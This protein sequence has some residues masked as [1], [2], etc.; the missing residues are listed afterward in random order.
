MVI[1]YHIYSS[2][3]HRLTSGQHLKLV[4]ICYENLKLILKHN[5]IYDVS[6]I[7]VIA[8]LFILFLG[9]SSIKSTDEKQTNEKITIECLELILKQVSKIWKNDQIPS[10]AVSI[11]EKICS[12]MA[13][14]IYIEED[15]ETRLHTKIF[16]HVI[17]MC[18]IKKGSWFTKNNDNCCGPNNNNSLKNIMA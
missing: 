1:A 5:S 17:G 13:E 12:L 2:N 8:H 9:N 7:G 15:K 3:K 4:S 11:V 14:V 18:Y 10:S 6:I 16:E